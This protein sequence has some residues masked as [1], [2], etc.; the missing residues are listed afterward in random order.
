VPGQSEGILRNVAWANASNKYS[1][2]C[3]HSSPCVMNAYDM[4][5]QALGVLVN[6]ER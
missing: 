2:K 1:R 4:V 3:M 6:V 5:A